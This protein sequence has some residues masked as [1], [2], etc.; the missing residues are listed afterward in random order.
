MSVFL[1]PI[2]T[3]TVGSGGAASVSFNSIPQGYTDLVVKMSVASVYSGGYDSL[4]MY[5]NGSQANESNTNLQGN[6]SSASSQRSTYRSIALINSI[7]FGGAN[8]FS[9]GEIY[10]PNYAGANYKQ[11][12]VDLV[13]EN[14]GTTGFQYM[15]SM[16][17]SQTAAI[18]S[19]SF[20][21]ATSGQ[22]IAQYSKFS[23]YGVLRQGI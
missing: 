3:Q 2:Y 18:T 13:A 10:I 17:W 1:Q 20:D 14:N 15:T 9:N 11:V 4:G 22:N 23:L 8:V 12:I 21:T 16:L 7:G 5:F 19:L 6:G